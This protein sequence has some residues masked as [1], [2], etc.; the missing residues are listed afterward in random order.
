MAF[1]SPAWTMR[2]EW[3]DHEPLAAAQAA[4]TLIDWMGIDWR[5]FNPQAAPPAAFVAARD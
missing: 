4:A 2:G 3:R 5:E 1:V